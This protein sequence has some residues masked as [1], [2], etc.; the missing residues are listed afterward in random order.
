MTIQATKVTVQATKVAYKGFKEYMSHPQIPSMSAMI[1]SRKPDL[2][3]FPSTPSAPAAPLTDGNARVKPITIAAGDETYGTLNQL[4][5][6]NKYYQIG[7]SEGQG[8][9]KT[10]EDSYGFIVDY[11]G[12][13]GQGLFAIF[14]GHGNK[15]AA[16]WCG[17]NF[18]K[19][20]K[21]QLEEN[22]NANIKKE[23]FPAMF[24]SMDNELSELS[25]ADANMATSGCTAAIAFLKVEDKKLAKIS[26][27][28]LPTSRAA[29][30]PPASA[31]RFLYCANVG[32]TRVVLSRGRKAERL[33]LDHKVTEGSEIERIRDLKGLIFRGRVLGYLNLTRSLGN[34]EAFEG[35][36]MKK[37]IIGTPYTTKTKLTP[38]D[39]FFILACDGLWDVM[40]DQE[41]VDLIYDE[42]D[43][44][45]AS[46]MLRDK[47]FEKYTHDNVTVMVV[48]LPKNTGNSE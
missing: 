29:L 19:H 17:D 1:P 10:M 16:E 47:A 20:L 8:E 34:H 42:E 13:R 23:V 18:H 24:E 26:S 11:G 22:P 38:E 27:E 31:K 40:T 15:L 2:D 25:Q 45:K 48:R 37:Y 28:S 6:N 9:R 33:T 36:S 12:I 35:F 32:D 39:E 5:L 3:N 4:R 21:R 44:E 41:A 14:D 30:D 43:P 7:V 46:Q